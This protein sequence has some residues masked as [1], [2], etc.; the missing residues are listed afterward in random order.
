MRKQDGFDLG[1]VDV[2][3]TRDNKVSAAVEDIEVA[4]FI[5]IANITRSKPAIL[6]G[7]GRCLRFIGIARRDGWPLQKNLAR[8]TR[9]RW[10]VI[11]HNA[12]VDRSE[13][14]SGGS[15]LAFCVCW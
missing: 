12:Q 8:L 9:S 13:R 4:I 15:G 3:S 6:K 1:G 11:I 14:A 5:E 2:L 10:P 7:L